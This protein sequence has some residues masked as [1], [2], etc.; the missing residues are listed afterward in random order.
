M[1]LL[2]DT[3]IFLW[4]VSADAKLAENIR[5]EI[6]NPLNAVYFSVASAWEITVKYQLGKLTLP[7]DPSRYIPRLRTE[8][9]LLSLEIDEKTITFLPRLP[10][11]HRDPFDRILICQALQHEL[12]LVTEDTLVR[13]YELPIFGDTLR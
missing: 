3:H 1:N 9:K 6:S 12:T 11:L 7:D 13:S 2:L 8:H 5:Q 4:Y 10:N